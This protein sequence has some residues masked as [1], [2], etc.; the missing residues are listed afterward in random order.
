M[1]R[2]DRPRVL[3]MCPLD[4]A[5]DALDT[6]REAAEV[7]YIQ[8]ADRTVALDRIGDADIFWGHFDLPVDRELIERGKKLRAICTASTGTDHID[9]PHAATRNIPI[10][11]I[12]RDY[13]LLDTFT[14]TAETNWMLL[15]ACHHRL[16]DAFAKVDAGGWG[17]EDLVG[18][19][20]SQRTLGVLGVG[21]LG[22]MIATFG[23]AF[24]M[25]VLG[26]DTKKITLPGVEQVDFDTLLH[27]SDAISINI[28]MTPDNAH[29]FNAAAFAKMKE[30]AILVN[31]SRGDI[32]DEPALLAALDSGRLA[33]FGADVLHDEPA[34]RAGRGSPVLEYAKTHGN[35][36]ITPHYAG[37]T[38]DTIIY[39][40]QFMAKKIVH[41]LKTG[42]ELEMPLD[43]S[44][45]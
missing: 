13:G 9:K 3:V 23:K 10:L 25:R 22:R 4:L 43:E 6:L 45:S 15:L 5:P 17:Y 41:F 37:A 27:E 7:Q 1:S 28:H 39:A 35:V 21:R 31:T 2:S 19:Q 29:L 26:C 8:P 18:R 36:V 38:N 12:A 14:S 34:I 30:G 33:A 42:D 40:R 16:R 32:I 44:K 24:R 20:L 11:S